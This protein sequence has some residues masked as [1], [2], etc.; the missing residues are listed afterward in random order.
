M[1]LHLL[2]M[3]I[4]GYYL[5]LHASYLILIVVG[6]LQLR[7]YQLEINFGEFQRIAD[8]PLTT[9]FSV[10]VPACDEEA[11]IVSTVLSA[12]NLYYP[13]HEVIVVNDGSRDR[14]L[15]VLVE[16]FGL[17]R[18]QRAHSRNLRTQLVR[19]VYE[20]SDY[21]NLVVVD[22][23][24]GKRADAINAAVNFA[25][26]PLLCIIDADSVLEEDALVR[27]VRPFLRNR[28]VIAAAGIVRPANGLI[29]KDGRIWSPRLPQ[30]WL[31]L[32][33]EIE[34][35]RSFQW[36]RIGL[37]KFGAMMCISGAFLMV[38]KEIFLEL[39]G[40]DPESITDDIDFTIRL[41]KY[42]HDRRNGKPKQIVYIPDPVCYTEVPETIRVHAAQRNRWQR[43]TLRA[44][45]KNWRMTFNPRYGAAGM[46]GMPFFFLF[47]AFSAIVE[48]F[49]YVMVP[50]LF[51]FGVASAGEVALFFLLAVML[52]TVQSVM[53]VLL[54]EST[55]LRP[56]TTRDLARLL[57][58]G[59]LENFGY[60]QMHLLWRIAGTFDYFVRRRTDLG[61][62][63]R[64]GNHQSLAPGK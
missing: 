14:T 2:L 54:Q 41:H 16:R 63:E 52:G 29:M 18:V 57:L 23:D 51:I 48:G 6:A 30:R 37:A 56:A 24:N 11:R 8:S 20:S 50:L 45:L 55:R 28:N 12:L 59:F 22:K 5:S 26:Y 43:G 64:Y 33:Q 34:Y 53:G 19:G 49:S 3:V 35:V 4:F 10:I 31:P 61:V 1:T 27:A 60:H 47:E 36:A 13:Q 42:A 21:P 44:L 39:G 38:R 62:M 7:K 32:F 58:A 46:I 15:Q 25:R 17:R 9:P 40:L